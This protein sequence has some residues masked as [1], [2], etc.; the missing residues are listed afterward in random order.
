M[1]WVV[2]LRVP[3]TASDRPVAA[4]ALH[5]VSF[6]DDKTITALD[7]QS[8]CL[9]RDCL[10]AARN[11]PHVSASGP[12][13]R[14]GT[15]GCQVV[16][17]QRAEQE[18]SVLLALDFN[19]VDHQRHAMDEGNLSTRTALWI[20]GLRRP[21]VRAR[22]GGSRYAPTALGVSEALIIR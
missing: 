7:R 11:A 18:M 15:R 4:G 5:H 22:Q 6:P 21:C 12:T 10:L 2:L 20:T 9:L 14:Y 3:Y 1:G 16:R 17:M 13:T 19:T 8:T